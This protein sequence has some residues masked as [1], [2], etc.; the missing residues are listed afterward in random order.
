MIKKNYLIY[1]FI[2]IVL[3]GC[4]GSAQHDVISANRAGD[5]NLTCQQIQAEMVRAQVVIHE[6]NADKS[7]ISGADV[8]DGLLWFP[9]NLIAKQQNYKNALQAADKRIERLYAL[10]KD[11]D[12][13]TDSAETE[14][15]K[16]K[17]SAE[18]RQLKEMYE[19][20]DLTKEEYNKAKNKL[21][22]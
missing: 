14:Q 7:G 2:S 21:L 3:F 4:A 16:S 9:F 15:K 12:C 5:E 8:V 11:K 18:L 19:A 17:I 13:Q 6:V 22:N 1:L 10:Q 20:G